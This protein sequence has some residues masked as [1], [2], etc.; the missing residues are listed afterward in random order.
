M[1]VLVNCTCIEL[2]R[3]SLQYITVLSTRAASWVK[4]APAVPHVANDVGTA[5][6]VAAAA[7]TALRTAPPVFEE[8]VLRL[9]AA[10]ECRHVRLPHRPLLLPTRHGV[11]AV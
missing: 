4:G 1:A 6:P 5:P 8:D 3:I 10:V 2:T 9:V 11:P 7:D